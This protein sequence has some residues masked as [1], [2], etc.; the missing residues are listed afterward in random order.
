[1]RR[2][3]IRI[4][5][6]NPIY[7][8]GERMAQENAGEKA[9]GER[10]GRVITHKIIPG[11][12]HF[13]EKQSFF[14]ASSKSNSGNISVSVLAGEEGYIKVKSE[15]TIEIFRSLL[16]SN[17]YDVFWDNVKEHNKVG[18][19]FIEPATRRRFRIN[20]SVSLTE[21]KVTVS[22]D[23][24]YPNCPKYIQQRRIR[25]INKPAYTSESL[26]GNAL[27]VA[28]LDIL[29]QADTF[30]VGSCD[31]HG[32]MDASHRGGAPGFIH[33][34]DTNTLLIPDYAGNSMFNTLGNFMVNP[35]AALLFLDFENKKS[36]Q[37]SGSAEI[38][39]HDTDKK[40]NT[41]GTNRFWMFI[42]HKWVLLENLKGFEWHFVDYSPFNPS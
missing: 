26:S 21:Q 30:F 38:I 35:Q 40:L 4:K 8:D 27:N 1:M 5:M 24:A 6:I 3:S 15:T 2:F 32:N 41:G 16:Y 22:V 12:I 33:I 14:I 20:G 42:I 31:L 34:E 36:L 17:P 13:M 18:L 19:L 9:I 29:R 25:L 39:W 23:Q 10:N 28:L 11:A 37:L 7:H